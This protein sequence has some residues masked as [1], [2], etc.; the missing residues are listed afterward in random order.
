MSFT[1]EGIQQLKLQIA[2]MA[3]VPAIAD[4]ELKLCA[5]ELMEMSTNM[6]PE[7]H[8][9]LKTAIQL[10]RRGSAERGPGGRFMKGQ[11]TYEIWINGRTPVTDPKK[12]KKG[13]NVVADYAWLVHAHM[14][15]AGSP[16]PLMPSEKSV[17][18]GRSHNVDAGGAFLERAAVVL[19]P[20][21]N[22][23]LAKVIFKYI[24]GMDS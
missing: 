23:R 9:D 4:E 11:S 16:Q 22:A 13:F 14:G 17:A 10:A 24:E 8:R 6:A 12:I 7:D 21:V 1:T 2:R 19:M 18:I 5:T 20:H 3:F 15:Y